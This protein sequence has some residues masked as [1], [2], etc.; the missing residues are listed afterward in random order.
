MVISFI[1]NDF[2][3]DTGTLGTKGIINY[4]ETDNATAPVFI[5]DSAFTNTN[6]NSI[7]VTGNTVTVTEEP[8]FIQLSDG[9]ILTATQ[10]ADNI[11][12]NQFYYS[13]GIVTF[14]TVIND[15]ITL[16]NNPINY[17]T[18][19]PT[20]VLAPP[21]PSIYYQ[22]AIDGIVSYKRS[23][24]GH[25]STE[26]TFTA[27][28]DS[29]NAII[30]TYRNGKFYTIYGITYQVQSINISDLSLIKY[31]Q[32][33]IVCS[34]NF[35]GQ[36]DGLGEKNILDRPVS[37][38]NIR[39]RYGTDPSG[40]NRLSQLLDCLTVP[41]DGDNPTIKIP[42]DIDSK[43]TVTI[44]QELESRAITVLGYPYYSDDNVKIKR[45]KVFTNKFIAD[46]DI[47]SEQIDITLSGSSYPYQGIQLVKELWN[48]K[49]ELAQVEEEE[50]GGENYVLWE[51]VNAI[52]EYD[53]KNPVTVKVSGNQL[54]TFYEIRYFDSDILRYPN[55]NFD[56][57]GITK[58][59]RKRT[60]KNGTEVT[61]EEWVY[62]F[63]F[64]SKDVY[65]VSF[66]GTSYSARY[67]IFLS[68]SLELSPHWMLVKY[69]NV[70]K[71]YDDK[72]NEYGT[73]EWYLKEE[74]TRGWNYLRLAQE[75]DSMETAKAKVDG[76]SEAITLDE[77]NKIYEKYQSFKKDF[78][79]II[80]YELEPLANYYDDIPKAT[81]DEEFIVPRFVKSKKITEKQIEVQP[82]P[83]STNENPKTDLF[84]NKSF[85]QVEETKIL[86]P[87]TI[88]SKRRKPEIYQFNNYILS[89]SGSGDRSEQSVTQMA[90]RPST[91]E[92]LDIS[93]QPF[94]EVLAVRDDLSKKIVFLNTPNSHKDVYGQD[95]RKCA[96]IEGETISYPDVTTVA[97]VVAIAEV[98]MA[99][100][101]MES[102]VVTL[103]LG[104]KY[105][106]IEG[107]VVHWR[108]KQWLVKEINESH[109]IES[110]RVLLDDY[111]ITLG[112]YFQTI[113]LT[114]TEVEN[115]NS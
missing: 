22:Y 55:A 8:I 30:E 106:L 74:I 17:S 60:F 37:L 51:Y 108:G 52:N 95:L 86:T 47:I 24:K 57:G 107:D 44:R 61:T 46:R 76:E 16:I 101:N 83:T 77:R 110:V 63:N 34:I 56:N 99:M 93:L 40:K 28:K 31:P 26:F 13:N 45:W 113:P 2:A 94:S 70:E 38:R 75:S 111:S 82:D 84:V 67:N 88:D 7:I 90:G 80:E 32:G 112:R 36:W 42:S 49:V 19:L 3:T 66:N 97:E 68:N 58:T 100:Q 64:Q 25:P 114:V 9:T 109:A 6:N 14:G 27:P 73:K 104:K 98:D 43:S 59:M 71:I 91:Q 23:F 5:V 54:A 20:T 103:K 12:T 35:T 1:S 11:A 41:F 81:E 65:D 105:S 10:D 53:V 4:Q 18:K 79:T 29:K 62:G 72:K 69:S 48:A 15:L 89:N 102:E 87:R 50:I 96:E 21:Y 92:R 33:L 39:K 85:V 78:E 115:D